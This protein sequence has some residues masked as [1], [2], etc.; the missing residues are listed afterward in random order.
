MALEVCQIGKGDVSTHHV[1]HIVYM[2]QMH[3]CC[4]YCIFIKAKTMLV[5]ILKKYLAIIV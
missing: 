2:S 4:T 3:G 1:F 5:R